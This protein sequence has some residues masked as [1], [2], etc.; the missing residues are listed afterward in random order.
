M[1]CVCLLA[2][3]VSRTLVVTDVPV[4][5]H[6]TIDL[7]DL[8]LLASHD[9]ELGS[10]EGHSEPLIRQASRPSRSFYK[11]PTTGCRTYHQRATGPLTLTSTRGAKR[12]PTFS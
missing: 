10:S 4:L 5:L 7:V 11:T 3:L 9:A 2:F 1:Q 6:H 12:S 8:V